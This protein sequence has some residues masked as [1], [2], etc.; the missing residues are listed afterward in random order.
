MQELFCQIPRQPAKFA[1]SFRFLERVSP[2][3]RCSFG[4]WFVSLLSTCEQGL[5]RDG[6]NPRAGH[7]ELFFAVF[8]RPWIRAGGFLVRGLG[9]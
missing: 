8:H 7:R 1:T 5:G 4:P 3:S 9:G 6:G 2:R